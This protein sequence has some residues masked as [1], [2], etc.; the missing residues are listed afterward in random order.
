LNLHGVFR[1]VAIGPEKWRE[2]AWLRAFVLLSQ[3]DAAWFR[4]PVVRCLGT[5]WALSE[6]SMRERPAVHTNRLQCVE[7][8]R[9]SR[10]NE[11]GWRAYLTTDEDEP[12]EAV[13]YCPDCNER[14]FGS[15][16]ASISPR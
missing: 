9:V 1:A 12:A 3:M 5:D 6:T 11:R 2:V 13:T 4:H 10:E 7:C 8:A 16:P 15:S 14:E